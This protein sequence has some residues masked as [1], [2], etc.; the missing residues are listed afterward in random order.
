[1]PRQ[2]IDPWIP[3]AILSFARIPQVIEFAVTLLGQRPLR[4]LSIVKLYAK[5][6]RLRYGHITIC[7]RQLAAD[8]H[9]IDI[10]RIDRVGCILHVMMQRGVNMQFGDLPNV[11]LRPTV[12]RH[13]EAKCIGRS[14]V[15]HRV[16]DP[17]AP[18]VDSANYR[19]V[20]SYF[21][22]QMVYPERF[23]IALLQ[24]ARQ[25]AE[26]HGG[27][28]SV[29]PYHQAA[30][31]GSTA[32][33]RRLKTDGN[34]LDPPVREFE[35]SV[36][37]NATGAWGDLTLRALGIEHERLFGGQAIREAAASGQT[38]LAWAGRVAMQTSRVRHAFAA[39]KKWSRPFRHRL[40]SR[41]QRPWGQT[42]AVMK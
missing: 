40:K 28:L 15:Q 10:F 31:E 2:R 11:A 33:I 34:T 6:R 38:E 35:P 24:D 39:L 12:Q 21:D 36:I 7:D 37:V 14:T 3:D 17:A 42:S 9:T 4:Q 41:T 5:S 32:R 18:P 23:V 29:L 8:Q 13:A 16:G 30:L 20:C 19:W 22:A 1:M 26:A 27:S 25:Y